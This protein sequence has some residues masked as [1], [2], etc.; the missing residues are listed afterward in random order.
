MEQQKEFLERCLSET[1]RFRASFAESRIFKR[2][3]E[4]IHMRNGSIETANIISQDGFNIRVIKDGAWGYATSSK[5][6]MKEI[7]KIASDAINVAKANR[8]KLHKP[9]ELTE[10]PI[11]SDN[12]FSPCKIDPF[13]VEYDEKLEVLKGADSV[14]REASDEIKV[15]KSWLDIFRV[16]LSFANSEGTRINQDQTF[17]GCLVE[18]TAASND[19]QVRDSMD[20][21]MKGYEFVKEFDFETEGARAAKDALLLIRKAKK[22]PK[23]KKTLIL[24]P[25]QLG[26]TIHESTGH[27]TE[28]DR[29]MEF[30]ADF[31][32]TSFLSIDKFGTN[33]KYGSELVNIVCDP[34]IP[35]GLGSIRYDDEGVEAQR[36]HIIKNGIFRNYLTDRE[37][38]HELGYE[39]S[40]G[41]ARISNYNRIPLIRMGNLYLEPD[42]QGPKDIEELIAETKDGVFGLFWKS[43]SIDDKRFNF[44]FSTQLG[45]L[46]EGGELVRPLKNVCYSASTPDFWGNCDMITKSSRMY[47]SGPNC[48]KGV[49]MQGMWTSEG[50]GWARFQNVSVFAS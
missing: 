5:L 3:T 25:F 34:T 2:L 49:P 38:A 24:E 23:G 30:E 27:P 4:R 44:Q 17:V 18:A 40:M 50:G 14:M 10:E 31:A 42:P 9:V 43:H 36:F 7:P 19:V 21:Q 20:Y 35:S 39:R 48:G 15:S 45:W 11:V 41:N 13:E 28:L 33:Y 12:Y 29:A 8:Q 22:C 26:L 32:G 1:D 37:L 47:S 6:D 16:Q 46:I